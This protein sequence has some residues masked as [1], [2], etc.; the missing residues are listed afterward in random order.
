MTDF[1]IQEMQEMQRALQDRYKHKW[2]PIC[3]ETGQ[4]KLL[5][6]VGEIG[7][8]IDIVEK[9][10]EA[11]SYAVQTEHEGDEFMHI[12]KITKATATQA[13]HIYAM[14]WKAA[15]KG[16]IPQAYLDV[17]PLDRWAD[18]LGNA[19]H[20]NFRAD[21]ILSDSGKFVASSSI[22]KARDEAYGDWGEIMSIYVL[23]EEF[24]KGYGRTLF[25]YVFDQLKEQGYSN[26][27]LWVLEENQRAR[28]FYDKMGFQANGD[29]MI[30]NIGGKDCVEV[31]YI[32]V[33]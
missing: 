10:G 14:S 19:E 6:M 13:S 23:P 22:C 9:H 18:K 12:E 8:V 1:S 2:E 7:E 11:H 27:Y 31:R 17:L 24:R 33:I 29:R 3:P 15:Y 5:W 16:I 4:N 21:Y 30:Q 26:I 32:N 25:T 28:R 20:E